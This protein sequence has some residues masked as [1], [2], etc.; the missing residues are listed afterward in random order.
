[1]HSDGVHE[2]EPTTRRA[3]GRV[4]AASALLLLCSVVLACAGWATE[5][6]PSDP[7][8]RSPLDLA[9]RAAALSRALQLAR[10][11]PP[12]FLGRQDTARTRLS[13]LQD[14]GADAEAEEAAAPEPAF[15]T[16]RGTVVESHPRKFLCEAA[17]GHN[18]TCDV[19]DGASKCFSP[20][21]A[22]ENLAAAPDKQWIPAGA[23]D[24]R[25]SVT[26]RLPGSGEAVRAILWANEGDEEHDPEWYA[27]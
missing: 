19:C 22:L 11:P 20:A 23:V 25:Q 7:G 12:P 18:Y 15:C 21:I 16:L 14:A 13:K 24:Q 4:A 8:L 2:H 9:A 3:A 6:R 26:I 5:G 17:A 27:I 10:P 1:M